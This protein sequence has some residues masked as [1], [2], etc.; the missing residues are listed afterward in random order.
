MKL[1]LKMKKKYYFSEYVKWVYM[2][3]FDIYAIGMWWQ[4]V[5][6]E[7]LLYLNGYIKNQ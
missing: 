7:L 1:K 5:A 6:F 4:F 3:L 2:N